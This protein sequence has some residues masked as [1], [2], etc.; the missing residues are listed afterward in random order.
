[1]VYNSIHIIIFRVFSSTPFSYVWGSLKTGIMKKVLFICLGNI[2]RSPAAE[3]IMKSLL[4]KKNLTNKFQLDSAGMI[5]Y[6]TGEGPD[7]RMLKQASERGYKLTHKARKFDPKK[8]FKKFDY[9]VTMD[10]QIF[11]DVNKLDK[12]N[13][14]SS[15]IYKMA[16]YCSHYNVKSVPDPY[17]EGPEAFENVLDILEDACGYFLDKIKDES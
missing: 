4:H 16:K 3:G 7:P 2:C 5:D 12:K 11:M 9:L 10:D 6:H 15:K 8:D 14:Y 1:M 17:D 13:E